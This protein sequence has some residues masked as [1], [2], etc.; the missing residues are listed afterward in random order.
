MAD[1]TITAASVAAG[2]NAA[3]VNQYLAG[4]TIT[5]GQAVYVDSTTNTVKLADADALA[6]SAATGIALNAASAG[7][8]ITYQR[9]G[10]ITIGATVAVG[11][12]Y[13]VSTTAGAI[14]LESDLST[15]N[16]PHFLGFAT[17]TTVIALDPKACGVAKA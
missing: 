9:Y 2:A 17:S 13:Y 6:S 10:N 15:G 16:F 14:C 12:A 3:L 7:Q 11:V 5:Q 8:P 1:L 4:A